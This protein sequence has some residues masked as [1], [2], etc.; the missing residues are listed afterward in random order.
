M[1][2]SLHPSSTLADKGKAGTEANQRYY[3]REGRRFSAG[4]ANIPGQGR[5]SGGKDRDSADQRRSQSSSIL[6]SIVVDLRMQ[7]QVSHVILELTSCPAIFQ[8]LHGAVHKRATQ[9]N[10]ESFNATQEYI[11]FVH[12]HRND[13]SSP[14][15]SETTSF[16]VERHAHVS[17]ATV[18]SR[19]RAVTEGRADALGGPNQPPR[20]IH[21]F[22]QS[23]ISLPR[24]RRLASFDLYSSRLLPYR[25]SIFGSHAS[26]VSR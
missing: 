8:K 19:L 18:E 24:P 23:I 21:L 13:L 22:T 16:P 1:S 14:G 9:V 25:P 10:I 15:P 12:A 3:A 2:P 11:E 4:A 6:A 17:T 7:L 20:G 5:S 26:L